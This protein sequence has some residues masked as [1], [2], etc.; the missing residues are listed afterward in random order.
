M[1]EIT[2][3]PLTTTIGARVEGVDLSEPLDAATAQHL[4][5]AL[6]AHAVLTFPR[7]HLDLTQQRAFAANFGELRNI[8]SH[9]LV[10][11]DDTM[12]VLDNR[13][14]VWA[15]VGLGL[16]A[17]VALL[18]RLFAPM[19]DLASRTQS[20]LFDAASALLLLALYPLLRIGAERAVQ[21]LL[22][23]DWRAREQALQQSLDGAAHLTGR[24]ALLAHYLAALGTYA[25]GAGAAV[26]QCQG[27]ACTR[28]AATLA[29]SRANA[30]A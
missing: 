21:A 2:V 26:Y 6:T 17:G 22:Y 4:R 13:L 16:A 12:V 19:L 7:Q 29:S 30:C 10:G 1:S 11:N 15:V 9:R 18:N 23:S 20:L 27:G 3:T 8:L 24:E 25:G 28:L 5:D 14:I